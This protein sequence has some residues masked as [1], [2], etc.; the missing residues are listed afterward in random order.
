MPLIIRRVSWI[1]KNGGPVALASIFLAVGLA[2]V[3]YRGF[4]H[5]GGWICLAG[6]VLVL[7]LSFEW[8]QQR[9]PWTVISRKELTA[10]FWEHAFE[11]LPFPAFVKE[12]PH[13]GHVKDSGALKRFQGDKPDEQESAETYLV[14]LIQQDHREG[15]RVAARSGLSV[16][17]ELTDEVPSWEPRAI[18]T[19]KSRLV[20]DKRKY[21]VGCYV[22]VILPADLS[23]ATS[24]KVAECGG[25]IL[26]QCPSVA[27]G[28]NH[29]FV[30]VG[31]SVHAHR[32]G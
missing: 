23:T 7:L 32:A 11:A 17:L 31:S 28:E 30:T 5:V 27:D 25:Q 15:D 24:L 20:Y 14:A 4:L 18:L 21:I 22:P 26:F 29:F 8:V 1:G 12:Y 6:A 2:L 16:Q 9:I 3:V 19:L 10:D 13:D